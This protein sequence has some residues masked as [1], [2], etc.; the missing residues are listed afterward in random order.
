MDKDV[1]DFLPLVNNL[2]LYTQIRD[3]WQ[4]Q[5]VEPLNLIFYKS[6]NTKIDNENENEQTNP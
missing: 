5:K 4:Q 6:N 1:I 3:F 2:S